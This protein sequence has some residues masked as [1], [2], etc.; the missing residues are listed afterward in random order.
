MM[1][2]LERRNVIPKKR[3]VIKISQRQ[4]ITIFLENVQYFFRRRHTLPYEVNGT[5]PGV[6]D[7]LE[8]THALLL[9]SSKVP[10]HPHSLLHQFV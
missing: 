6:K 5:V 9:S 4:I 7:V 2:E 1:K 8:E 10:A 3:W